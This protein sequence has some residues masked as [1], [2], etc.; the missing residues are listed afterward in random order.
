MNVIIEKEKQSQFNGLELI[1]FENF[2]SWAFMEAIGSCLTNK[3][4]E[5]LPGK[6]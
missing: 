6:R 2:T 5:G 1:S 3:Y 4:L